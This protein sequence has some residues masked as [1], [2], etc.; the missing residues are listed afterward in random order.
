MEGN[1]SMNEILFFNS[2][3]AF[4]LFLMGLM[5]LEGLWHKKGK[6]LKN[7]FDID[8]YFFPEIKDKRIIKSGDQLAFIICATMSSLT[9][10]NGIIANFVNNVPNVSAIF[11]FIA[12]FL[13]WPIRIIFLYLYKK[14][15]YEELPKI[16][17][18]PKQRDKTP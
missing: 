13:S 10:L 9:L 3:F 14:K 4:I 18:F 16:W 17:P 8:E 2:I 7:F 5:F 6:A 11:I 1:R 15:P 12:V